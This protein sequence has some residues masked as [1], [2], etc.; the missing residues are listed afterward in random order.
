MTV[1]MAFNSNTIFKHTKG[2]NNIRIVSWNIGNMSGK[3]QNNLFKR[4]TKEEIVGFLL[5]QN[6]DIICL[7]EFEECKN[8]CKTVSSIKEKY[9]YSFFPGQII[10]PY[11]HGSG[12]A[13]FSKFPIVTADSTRYTNGEN[14]ITT[15]VAIENDTVSFYT[16]HFDSYK[17]SKEEFKEIDALNDEEKLPPKNAKG[18]LRKLKRTLKMHNEQ[19]ATAIRFMSNSKYPLIFCADMNEVPNSYTYWN[20]RGNKQDAFLQKG[21]GLGKTFN[22][23]SPALR[24]DY[25]M[26]DSNFT[27]NQFD[28]KDQAMSDHSLLVCDVMLKKY[29][30]EK[31]KN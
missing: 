26:P 6:A 8:G 27:V 23:L 30:T 25:I 1:I 15:T 12:C 28:I 5:K 29:A 21:F 24:I 18:I 17:F 13:I 14:I 19:A 3:P 20:M 11:R 2:I 4:H 10:G 22:S 7:Q 9:P 16:T 31:S